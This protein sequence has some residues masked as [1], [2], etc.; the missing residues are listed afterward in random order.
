MKP[1]QKFEFLPSIIA[2]TYAI[3]IGIFALDEPLL[4]LGF[5][6][7]LIPSALV[8]M[9]ALLIKPNNKAAI[10]F[11]ILTIL[12][13]IYFNTYREAVTFAII[14]GPLLIITALYSFLPSKKG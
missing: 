10:A 11:A 14:T 1:P 3:F 2:V 13:T 6:L 5:F 12:F 8:L 4:S 7:H 9:A